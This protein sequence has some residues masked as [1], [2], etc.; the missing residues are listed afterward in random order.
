MD[1]A[2][3][4]RLIG[5]W[6]GRR[7]LAC[8]GVDELHEVIAG[9][10]SENGEDLPPDDGLPSPPSAAQIR[11]LQNSA[12]NLLRMILLWN[13]GRVSPDELHRF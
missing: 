12:A 2:E 4:K 10:A 7:L 3:R 8:R 13:D 5:G 11:E 1:L 6:R 9:L